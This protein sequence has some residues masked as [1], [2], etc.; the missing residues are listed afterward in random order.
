MVVLILGRGYVGTH[1]A[2]KLGVNH[3]VTALSRAQMDYTNVMELLN[4]VEANGPYD[5][6]INASGYTG[7][8]NV[9]A[10]EAH[11]S[12]TWLYNVVLPTHIHTV[13]ELTET[14]MVHISSGCIFT[15]KSPWSDGDTDTGWT[16][17]DEPNFGMHR[18]DSSW[19]SKTKHAAELALTNAHIFRIR[20][21][22]DNTSSDRNIIMKLLKYR[23]LISELNSLTCINDFAQFVDSYISLDMKPG[24]YN[25]TN[26]G[27]V[28]ATDI[29]NIMKSHGVENPD[30]RFIKTHHLDTVAKRSNCILDSSKI[31]HFNLDLPDT[32]TSLD[33][34]MTDILDEPSATC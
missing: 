5:I 18:S 23:H 26:P 12:D 6:I 22:F 28:T 16:E 32:L 11:K 9:D 30:W 25:V 21:P 19:Y 3:N 34:C 13:C 7:R 33:K 10:C 31:K 24:I 27:P 15:G 1:L 2:F 20:M 8:P 17:N 4:W 29:T 14:Q